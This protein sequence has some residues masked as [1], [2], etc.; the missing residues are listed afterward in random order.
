MLVKNIMLA[1]LSLK[2]AAVITV[3]VERTVRYSVPTSY[4]KLKN[5][6]NLHLK[7][8]KKQPSKKL[9]FVTP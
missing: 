9:L 4:V 1:S 3:P 8:L 2:K 7:I 5:D 6:K